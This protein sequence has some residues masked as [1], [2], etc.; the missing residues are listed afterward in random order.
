MSPDAEPED[1]NGWGMSSQ[2]RY[3]GN[4][5]QSSQPEGRP[6][7]GWLHNVEADTETAGIKTWRPKAQDR[8][9]WMV[10]QREAKAT[11]KG[12]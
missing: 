8:K 3:T 7:L 2:Y 9:E 5:T 4:D 12:P 10:I 11:I 1:W 6:K